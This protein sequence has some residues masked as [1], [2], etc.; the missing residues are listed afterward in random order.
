MRFARAV[1]RLTPFPRTLP[2]PPRLL[3]PRV[4]VPPAEMPPWARSR[5]GPGALRDAAAL[6]LI[7]AGSGGEAT[8]VLTER[9][10]GDDVHAGQVAL[11]G[12]KRDP[13]DH[14]PVGTALREAAEEVGL[15]VVAARVRTLG[16]LEPVQVRVSGFLLVPVVAVAESTPHLA[17][18]RHEVARLLEVPIRHFL[19]R[20]PIEVVEDVRE[21]WSLRY[22]AYP[23]GQHRIWGATARVLGQLGALLGDD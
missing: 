15:D 20:A 16:L 7:Y 1:A 9:P 5:T 4:V 22:G 8:I 2:D 12:G 6:V 13:G 18:D 21:G 3:E 11:P 23:V 14:Y 10:E 17:P 19:P